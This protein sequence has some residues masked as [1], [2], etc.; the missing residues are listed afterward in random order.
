MLLHTAFAKHE[1]WRHLKLISVS[2]EMDNPLIRHEKP[3]LREMLVNLNSNTGAES[4]LR[5]QVY[6]CRVSVFYRKP[7]LLIV[8]S[9]N[10]EGT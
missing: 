1:H 9:I 4:E 5:R 3:C 2:M 10:K 6:F 8:I 7:A